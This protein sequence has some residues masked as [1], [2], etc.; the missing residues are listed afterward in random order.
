MDSFSYYFDG[1]TPHNAYFGMHKYCQTSAAEFSSAKKFSYVSQ[2]YMNFG[3][4]C[5]EIKN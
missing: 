3:D 2:N 5:K 1:N 4:K